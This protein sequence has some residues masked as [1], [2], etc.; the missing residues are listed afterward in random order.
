MTKQINECSAAGE[1]RIEWPA[2]ERLDER[3]RER[4]KDKKRK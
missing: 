2:C 4:A 1:L 3:E